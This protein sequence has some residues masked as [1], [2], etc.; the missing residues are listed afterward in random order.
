VSDL[1]G[2]DIRLAIAE[3]LHRELK[4]T[5]YQPPEIL[6]QKVRAGELG[7]KTGKGFYEWP[8]PTP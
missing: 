7:R 5:Q 2:L 4:S 1:V 6:R 8:T 3:H